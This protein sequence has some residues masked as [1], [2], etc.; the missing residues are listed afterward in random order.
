[1]VFVLDLANTLAFSHVIFVLPSIDLHIVV[2][3]IFSYLFFCISFAVDNFSLIFVPISIFDL[4]DSIEKVHN[5]ISGP[6]LYD[7]FIRLDLIMS[8]RTWW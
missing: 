8:Y 3:D 4:E 5:A 1:M 2:L 6:E 7:A